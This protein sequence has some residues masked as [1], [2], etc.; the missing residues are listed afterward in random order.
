MP[1]A[2][3]LVTIIVAF[4]LKESVEEELERRKLHGYSIAT[5]EGRGRHGH[6]AGDFVNPRNAQFTIVTTDAAAKSILT[7]VE[8]NLSEDPAIAYSV[9]VVAVPA[10]VIH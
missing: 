8:A 6:Q 2:A 7:W 10:R 9:D 3:K 4:E 1:V 5:V